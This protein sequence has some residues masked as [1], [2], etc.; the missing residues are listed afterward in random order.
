MET[1]ALREKLHSL[2]NNSSEEKLR[3]VYSVFEN[4]YTDEFN[5]DLD[6]EYADYQ[7]SREVVSREDLNEIIDKLLFKK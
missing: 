2:I 4:H 7:E 6:K 3:E 5:A 1:T